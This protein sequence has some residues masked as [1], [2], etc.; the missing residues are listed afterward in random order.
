VNSNE[1]PWILTMIE[2]DQSTQ[3]SATARG[4]RTYQTNCIVCHGAELKGDRTRNVP[5]LADVRKRLTR[6]AVDQ[7]VATG[8][9]VMPAFPALSPEDR[10]ELVSYLFGDKPTAASRSD[11]DE[12]EATVPYTT[13]GYNRFF[14][15]EGYPAVKPPWGTLNAIDLN[16]GEIAWKVPL[17][18]LP[19][20][21]KRGRP[22]TGTENYG[23]PIVTAGGLVF[24]GATLY[25][26]KFH[27]FDKATGALL[28]ESTLPAAG[29]AT[30]ATYMAGGRQFVVIAAGGGKSKDAPGASYVAYAL[31]R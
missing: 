30:P 17:G 21:V 19:E 25:D 5:S 13:T 12:P 10:R 1:M 14:D 3:T 7:T 2:I 15:P 29:N 18:E 24:I 4:K 28:W 11:P 26:R 23:G 9:G 16:R 22:K 20:L 31:P 6:D 8:R 27:A